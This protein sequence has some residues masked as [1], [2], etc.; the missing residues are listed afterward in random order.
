MFSQCPLPQDAK[1]AR[2]LREARREPELEAQVA[3]LAVQLNM[4]DEVPLCNPM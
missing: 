4:V 1:A 2:A 3:M